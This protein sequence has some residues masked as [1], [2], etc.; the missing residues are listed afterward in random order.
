M[1]GDCVC[2]QMKM[3]LSMRAALVMLV[4]LIGIVPIAFA[5]GIALEGEIRLLT[6]FTS[7]QQVKTVSGMKQS[8]RQYLCLRRA[9]ICVGISI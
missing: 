4:C 6:R 1:R 7:R 8:Q 5:Q 2:D 3:H 9:G